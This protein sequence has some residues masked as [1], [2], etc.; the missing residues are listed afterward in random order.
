MTVERPVV[1]SELER[2]P[3]GLWSVLLTT[4]DGANHRVVVPDTI[5]TVHGVQL[6][7]AVV[8]QLVR[9]GA[10]GTKA[11]LSYG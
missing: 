8:D 1:V 6:T 3:G 2:L 5:A 10:I 11:R 9:E 4:S 7:A